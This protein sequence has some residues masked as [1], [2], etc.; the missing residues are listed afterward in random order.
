MIFD[1]H[2]HLH[3]GILPRRGDFFQLVSAATPEEC[4]CLDTL[5]GQDPRLFYSCGVHP[6]QSDTVPITALTPWL[7]AACALGEIGMDSVWCT[8]DLA[9]QRQVFRAQLRL[10][11]ALRKPVILHT[12]GCEQAV[13]EEIE[14]FPCPILVHWYSS[15]EHLEGYLRRDCYFTVGPDFESNLAVRQVAAAV[16]LHRLMVE[17]DGVAGAA[18]ALGRDLAASELPDLLQASIQSL[19]RLRGIAPS[20]MEELLF[21]NALRFITTSTSNGKMQDL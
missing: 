20:A 19:A 3:Q 9:V 16:P 4:R 1:A 8:V 13:L 2:T 15:S 12:K 6:W 18:W 14:S 10:A 21:Q 17:S 7:S 5:R 11:E